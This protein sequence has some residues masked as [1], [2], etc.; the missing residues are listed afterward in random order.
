MILFTLGGA[1]S[2]L[3]LIL[4]FP[5]GGRKEPNRRKAAGETVES[6]EYEPPSW[7]V[8]TVLVGVV[9]WARL[10]YFLYSG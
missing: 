1:L 3:P 9:A 7:A 10:S 2:L 5:R 4:F 8:W 6:K